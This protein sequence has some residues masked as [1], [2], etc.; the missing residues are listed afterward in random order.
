[1]NSFATDFSRR[2]AQNPW[3]LNIR[4]YIVFTLFSAPII[5]ILNGVFVDVFPIGQIIRTLIIVA[6]FFIFIGN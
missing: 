3:M 4:T 6:N 5:D 2:N 1:M